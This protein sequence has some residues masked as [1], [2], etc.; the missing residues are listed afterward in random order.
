MNIEIR[1]ATAEDADTI[2]ELVV[3]LCEYEGKS[4]N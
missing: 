4:R 2:V 1:D 3:G